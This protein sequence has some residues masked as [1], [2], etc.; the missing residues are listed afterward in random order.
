MKN[1][2][3]RPLCTAFTALYAYSFFGLGALW[4]KR[5][6]YLY[7]MDVHICIWFCHRYCY[8]NDPLSR[9]FTFMP[10]LQARR[11]NN[12]LLICFLCEVFQMLFPFRPPCVL[13]LP[14]LPAGCSFSPPLLSQFKVLLA[15]ILDWKIESH[16]LHQ[17]N[18]LPPKFAA[19]F[20]RIVFDRVIDNDKK[21]DNGPQRSCGIR[22]CEVS[23]EKLRL[24]TL[25]LF[26]AVNTRMC[27]TVKLQLSRVQAQ[28]PL[29]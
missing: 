7:V 23:R 27:C 15:E 19:L 12:I 6:I 17:H 28:P 2:F 20:L 25:L 22:H 1:S 18:P 8:Q 29:C 10:H 13:P 4:M 5:V 16:T 9:S 24:S 14:L 11:R 3:W 26:H 21:R